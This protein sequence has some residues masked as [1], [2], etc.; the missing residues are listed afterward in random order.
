MALTPHPP[1]TLPDVDSRRYAKH[2]ITRD[3]AERKTHRLEEN[4]I[5]ALERYL[6]L[7]LTCWNLSVII[8][9]T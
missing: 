7:E 4:V 8:G 1:S 5:I 2:S 3:D 6:N 9:T